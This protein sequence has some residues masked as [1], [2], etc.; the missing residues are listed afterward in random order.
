MSDNWDDWGSGSATTSAATKPVANDDEWAMDTTGASNTAGDS[1]TNGG[2]NGRSGGGR[3]CFNCHQSG[4]MSR[5][6]PEPRKERS[7][8]RKCYNCQQEGHSSRDCTEPKKENSRSCFNCNASDHMSRDCPQPKKSRALTCFNCQ[9]EG[10]RSNDCTEPKKPRNGYNSKSQTTSNT[11]DWGATNSSSTATKAN[12][13]FDWG[14]DSGTTSNNNNESKGNSGECHRCHE[15]GHMA[16]DC[17]TSTTGPNECR[18]CKKTGHKAADCTEEVIGEDGKPIAP[19]Y[20]P[21]VIDE[22]SENLYDTTPAGINFN[23]YDK[24]KVNLSGD[25]PKPPAIEAFSDVIKSDLM[26]EAINKC[27]YT[28]PTPVQKYAIPII[29]AERDLMACAQTGSGKTAAFILPILQNLLSLSDLPSMYGQSP[30]EPLCVIIS[31]TRELAIQIHTEAV[32]FAKGSIV[33][34]CL[35]YG[36]TSVGFQL[37][38]ISRGA[39]LLVATPGRLLDFVTKGKV[40]FANLKYLVLDEAD[41]M[42]DQ[43]FLPEVRRMVTHE[44]M[45]DKSKRQTL[46]FSATFP[47]EVQRLAQ[48]FLKSNYMFLT[49]GVVGSANSDVEQTFLEVDG[50]TKR[51]TLMDIL[52]KGESNERTLIF[53]EK[54]KTADFL[55]SYLSQNNM[56]T[57]SI[58]GDRFQSQREQALHDFRSGRMPILVATSVAARG[59]DIKD[60]K[61]VVNY[62]LPHEIDEYVHRIGR[63][64][65]VGNIGKA[66]SFFDPSSDNDI[67]LTA[68]LIKILETADQTVPEF[69]QNCSSGVRN[70]SNGGTFGGTDFRGD[71]TVTT[72]TN[73]DDWD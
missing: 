39:H 62:D 48:E 10:H 61:H 41:R 51:S 66:T 18:R 25:D 72:T 53:V 33:K 40:S 9:Q 52:R 31:P 11:D 58:H 2:G 46:M 59:L 7:G 24:I 38:H 71:S 67:A 26:N 17:P 47:D 49:V 56:M 68:S 30:Q 36:G 27:K 55:A 32:K 1:W 6:C 22:D 70:I 19:I 20:K 4:H 65:R 15:T 34:P 3:D 69:L 21:N 45:P 50:K 29:A 35:V 23:R 64:G 54:K 42:I 5:E 43:G 16:R 57:T 14:D 44:T 12:D 13:D 8:P 73:D 37:A 63:T 28:K 60:V